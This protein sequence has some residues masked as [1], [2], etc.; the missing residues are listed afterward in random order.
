MNVTMTLRDDV[1]DIVVFLLEF[2]G[3]LLTIGKILIVLAS[4]NK[5]Y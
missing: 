5:T 4:L 2:K 1:F 3:V